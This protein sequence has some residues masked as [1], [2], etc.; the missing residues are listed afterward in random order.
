MDE[1]ESED[2][3]DQK[4]DSSQIVKGEQKVVE[5]S[6][7][8]ASSSNISE[9]ASNLSRN[10]HCDRVD[11]LSR[12]KIQRLDSEALNSESSAEKSVSTSTEFHSATD[13][14]PE[15]KPE[16]NAE[17]LTVLIP[18]SENSS[19]DTSVEQNHT[20]VELNIDTGQGD[21]ADGRSEENGTS[22]TNGAADIV[23]E[24]P[25]E[26]PESPTPSFDERCEGVNIFPN[27]IE[28]RNFD[29]K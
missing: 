6:T 2:T 10:S 25:R 12:H 18:D 3:R 29:R 24:R 14:Q 23:S 21:D 11:E 26:S 16:I 28:K 9:N 7:M 17:V 22:A 27:Q 8:V 20:S 5:Q 13:S 15:L 19:A 4:T 1:N